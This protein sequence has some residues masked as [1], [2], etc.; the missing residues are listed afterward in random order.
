MAVTIVA[1][2]LLVGSHWL[3]AQSPSGTSSQG[4]KKTATS[5]APV[6]TPN[7]REAQKHYRI[8]LEAL[9]NN[10]LD[11][12]L[13]ELNSAAEL[14]PKNALIWYNIALV[15]SKKGDSPQS[16]LD[17]LQKSTSLGLPK[18]IRNDA[19]QL[20]AKLSYDLKR[21]TRKEAFSAKL[22][23]LQKEINGTAKGECLYE[24][25][26]TQRGG[27]HYNES[28][29]YSLDL[30]N[31]SRKLVVAITY[32]NNVLA[33]G[34]SGF[35]TDYSRAAN[36]GWATFD[37][38]DLIPDVR[39]QQQQTVCPNGTLRYALIAK[40][41][42]QGAIKYNGVSTDK[43]NKET[44]WTDSDALVLMFPRQDSAETAAKTFSE[45]IRMRRE[46]GN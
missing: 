41:E 16:A 43:T 27:Y 7:Q 12:A 46:M 30:Q 23:E 32:Y 29:S 38:T 8:A 14:D 1:A 2:V 20:E 24:N 39:I 31:N 11:I 9:K 37:L 35:A 45:A 5:A 40:S 25:N 6:L 44:P 17:H 21:E 15:E 4:S 19:D 18:T 22:L 3:T 34:P 28:Y 26:P 36:H 33:P 10:D 13:Q 42:S